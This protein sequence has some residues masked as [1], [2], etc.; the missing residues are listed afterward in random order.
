MTNTE[1]NAGLDEPREWRGL[2]GSAADADRSAQDA[3]FER[4]MYLARVTGWPADL[5]YPP[6]PLE[7]LVAA[8]AGARLQ[9][10]PMAAADPR[11]LPPLAA[12]VLDTADFALRNSG[13]RTLRAPKRSWKVDV[14]GDGVAGMSTLNLKS[15][16]NDASQMREALAWNAFRAAGVAASRHTYARLGIN[17]RYLGLFSLIEQVDKDFLRG[18]FTGPI[19]GNLYKIYCG[20]LGPGTLEHRVGVGGDDSGRQYISADQENQTYRLVNSW[21]KLTD[22]QGYDDLAHLVRVVNGI[23]LP[24]GDD[25]FATDAYATALS[26][27]FDVHSFLRWAAVNVLAG[28]WD[29]YFATPA[30]YYLYNHGRTGP[31]SVVSDPWFTLIPWDYDNSFGI[32]YFGTRWQY[33]DLLD[34]PANTVDYWRRNNSSTRTSRIPL[35]QNVIRNTEFRRYYLEQVEQLLDGAF[36]SASVD[37]AIGVDGG[38]L[39]ER[40]RIGAYLESDTPHGRPFT[41]RQ[42]T[43]DEVYRNGFAQ[44]ELRRG[45][46]FVLGIHHYLRMRHDRAREQLAF[47]RGQ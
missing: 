18:H 41:G 19:R 39:W 30:N 31:D 8:P 24:G 21:S 26:R 23:G 40:V 27:T 45:D 7:E 17:D 10:A 12:P 11:H 38:G 2:F 42:F 9:L 1:I 34:W 16:Y 5:V 32:D 25:R 20:D 14:G 46:S 47:L 6:D 37:A 4:Q 43:N 44:S 15:M 36:A 33:T 22:A 13:N 35:V 3:F 28:S 29:N